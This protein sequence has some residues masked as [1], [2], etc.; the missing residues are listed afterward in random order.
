MSPCF[1][2]ADLRIY[3][4]HCPLIKVLSQWILRAT[5]LDVMG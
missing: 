3:Q 5:V 1:G 2:A 4:K